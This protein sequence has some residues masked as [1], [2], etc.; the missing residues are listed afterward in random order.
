METEK[1]ML[2]FEKKLEPGK[3]VKESLDSNSDGAE[4]EGIRNE[5]I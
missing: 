3:E 2:S 4:P 1:I 5:M